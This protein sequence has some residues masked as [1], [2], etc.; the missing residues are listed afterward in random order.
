MK[1]DIL[2]GLLQIVLVLLAAPILQGWIKKVKAFWQMRQGPPLSQPMRDL[3]KLWQKEEVV[4]EHASWVFLLTPA[5]VMGSVLLAGLVVP[6][7]LGWPAISGWG[8][9]F[10]LVASFSLGRLFLSL[11]GLDAA[12]SFGGMGTSRELFL[13]V[14]V[15]P[16]FLLSLAVLA[17]MTGTTSLVGI[18]NGLQI[19]AVFSVPR[20]L[21]ILALFI[22]GIAEMGRI[23]VDNPDT[24]LELTMIH[25]GI[26][27]EYSGRS[28]A[29]LMWA[30]Q[31]KQLLILELLVL[32]IWPDGTASSWASQALILLKHVIKLALLGA[33]VATI[34]SVSVKTRLFRLPS[35]LAAGAA[36]AALA[37]ITLWITGGGL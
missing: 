6:K 23:P 12:G 3:Y 24:H 31:I 21:A 27:L 20:L 22:V 28:L 33:L 5:V 30:S 25:E 18:S 32:F 10:W 37:L 26:L 7:A 14:L 19:I 36:S 2:S 9:L 11:A 8:D 15:E 34:E 1:F 35:F 4:S 13:G 29:L 16:V 17:F